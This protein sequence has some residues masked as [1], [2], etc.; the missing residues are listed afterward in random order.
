MSDWHITFSLRSKPPP[1]LNLSMLYIYHNTARRLRRL[2][3]ISNIKI[4]CDKLVKMSRVVDIFVP[5][6]SA[7]HE[8]VA[9]HRIPGGRSGHRLQG[10]GHARPSQSHVR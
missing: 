2:S 3:K 6:L 9:G 10:D 1:G 4:S 8:A 5:W 7:D